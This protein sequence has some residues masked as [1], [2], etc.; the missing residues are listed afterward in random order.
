[1]KFWW[2]SFWAEDSATVCWP[3]EFPSWGSGWR[4]DN[5][6]PCSVVALIQAETEGEVRRVVKKHYPELIFED[7]RFLSERV[8]NRQDHSPGSRFAMPEWWSL[9]PWGFVPENDPQKGKVMQ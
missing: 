5:R 2:C 3:P 6:A 1:M 8:P 4:D 9:D 7:W